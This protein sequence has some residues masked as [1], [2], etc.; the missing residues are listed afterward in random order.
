MS[1]HVIAIAGASGFAGRAFTDALLRAESF[2]VRTLARKA[3]LEST[4]FQ[5]FKER[6]ASLH[7]ISYDDEA[8]LVKALQGVHVL[9]ST[10]SGSGTVTSQVPLAKAAK[11]AGVQTFFP[12]EYGFIYEGDSHLSPL[13]NGKK[14][15]LKA[16]KDIGLPTTIIHNGVF[17]K[18]GLVPLFGFNLTER[19][20]II[21]GDGNAKNAWTSVRSIGDW[22]AGVLKTIPVTQLQDKTF[23]IHSEFLSNNEVV[24]LWEKKHNAKLD[25]EY[26][27]LKELED[28]LEADAND[29]I[30]AILL[31][32]AVGHKDLPFSN[33]LYPDWKPE[34]VAE[35][36]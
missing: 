24:K 22:I 36:P 20:V 3:S 17:P 30:A 28:R 31:Q 1:A 19:K 10:I 33:G 7:T 25:V 5:E 16:A 15:V 2:E 35:L 11:I 32:W 29:L 9:I 12:S 21:W 27:P 34:L 13:L 18:Y 26:R 6:G 23:A 4:P 14:V 8:S